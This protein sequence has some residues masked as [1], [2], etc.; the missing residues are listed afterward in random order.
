MVSYIYSDERLAEADLRGESVLMLA[1]DTE[2]VKGAAKALDAM[3][4]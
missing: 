1:E 3:G 2:I 4:I